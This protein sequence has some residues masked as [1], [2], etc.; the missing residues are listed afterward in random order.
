MKLT[1][2]N[3]TPSA[4]SVGGRIGVVSGASVVTH[5]VTT[6]ELEA[7]RAR[8][9]ALAAASAIE[10][11]TSPSSSEE[12]D[13]AEVATVAYVNSRAGFTSTSVSVFV[14][15]N[16]NDAEGDG[17]LAS[18]YA[19]VARALRDHNGLASN[20][21]AFRV[22]V[23]APYT[24]PGFS[25][26]TTVP[27]IENTGISTTMQPPTVVVEAY[28]DSALAGINDPRFEVEVGP[29]TASAASIANTMWVAYTVP[30]GS[31]TSAHVGKVIRVFRS[32]SE[33]GRGTLAH[34]ITGA[35]DVVYLSQSR[36][37][38]PVAAWAPAIGD[39]LYACEHTVVF[40][41]PVRIGVGY[42][43][44]F[45]LACCKVEV[46][47]SAFTSEYAVSI[48]SGTA[49]LANVRIINTST[50]R[51]EG[52]YVNTGAWAVCQYSPSTV[53]P[54][55]DATERTFVFM[56]GGYVT[57]NSLATDYGTIVRGECVLRGW[58]FDKKTAA[59][60]GHIMTAGMWLRG[61]LTIGIGSRLSPEA[62][63]VLGGNRESPYTQTPLWIEGADVGNEHGHLIAFMVDT[64]GY[65]A[66]LPI[67][68]VKKSRFSSRLSFNSLTGATTISAPVVKA[69]DFSQVVTAA[70]NITNVTAGQDVQ[71]GATFAA[72]AGLP[73]VDAATLTR[74]STT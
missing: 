38:G 12:D 61:Q 35:S 45:V 36:T 55:M 15:Q 44:A 66:A 69:D 49:N 29:V 23:V 70:G 17:T 40:N 26:E 60:G 10:W 8:L 57:A 42:R 50:N 41:S 5:D 2:T 7:L 21:I 9:T 3:R 46:L 32:G 74:I 1:V 47:G 52:L 67:C 16:G 24:G 27:A 37:S 31:F 72:F 59:L 18:P 53:V 13:S 30:T 54:W 4:V 19:T 39:S 22:E 68:N 64:A 51:D 71:A 63:C 20:G 11:S 25:F 34:I 73:I 62:P 56:S 48:L 43:A 6:A 14:A 33:V 58:V 65:A 28:Y